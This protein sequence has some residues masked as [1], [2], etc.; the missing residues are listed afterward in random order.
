MLEKYLHIH[1]EVKKALSEGQPVVALESTIISH[2]MPYP[3][4][5]EMAKNVSKIIRDNGAIP[6][7]IAIIDGILKVGLTSE[8]IEFLGTS[9]NVLKASRRDLPFIISKKLNGAT[10]VATTMILANLAGVKVFATG[11]IGGVHRGAQETFDISADL[12]ELANTNVAVVCAGAK[13]ILDIGLT[14][15]YLETNGVPVVGFGT[16]D[17]PA[18]YT[19]KSGFGVDYKVDSSIEVASA[20]KAKWDLDLKGGMV[21]GNPIPEN[22]EMDYDTINNAIE[23]AL[24]EADE[25][26]ITGKKV[27]PFLLDKVKTI[28]AGK[29]L[30]ANI[31]LVY[32]NAK[33]A[34]QIAKDLSSLK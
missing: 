4:N 26:N 25:N 17:F 15:E 10:T 22:F 18:F 20:L 32:N 23:T 24:K 1:P 2:G 33:V 12:Q 13:S 3:K 7:T 14:L 16:E 6:A 8:E 28:T 31:E 19:R 9:K 11:G 27:T 21:I 29:S 30:E 5:V 34:A